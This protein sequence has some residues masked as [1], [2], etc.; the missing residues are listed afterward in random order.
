MENSVNTAVANIDFNKHKRLPAGS[1]AE[2]DPLP[3]GLI[4]EDIVGLLMRIFRYN[5]LT[6]IGKDQEAQDDPGLEQSD[7]TDAR[8]R[9]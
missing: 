9:M 2:G 4:Y 3:E 7:I 5:Y 1:H 6:S 8:Q